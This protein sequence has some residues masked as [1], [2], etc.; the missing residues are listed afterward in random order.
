MEREKKNIIILI[1]IILTPLI[2]GIII[3][4]I[5]L[6]FFVHPRVTITNLSSFTNGKPQKAEV[7]KNIEEFLYDTAKLNANNISNHESALVREGTFLQEE[8]WAVNYVSFIVDIDSIQQSFNVSYAWTDNKDAIVN[9]WDTYITC[10]DEKNKKYQNSSCTD[11]RLLDYGTN[12][13][14]DFILPYHK[15]EKFKISY[16]NQT[17]TILVDLFGCREEAIKDQK[18]EADLWLKNNIKGFKDYKIEY[19]SCTH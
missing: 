8:K 17:K 18:E 7:V 2:I 1:L 10:V 11:F 9:E 4:I 6:L 19:E 13:P 15:V 14:I 12:D 16:N 3:F 5:Y